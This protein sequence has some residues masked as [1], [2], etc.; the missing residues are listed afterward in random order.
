MSISSCETRR[1]KCACSRKADDRGSRHLVLLVRL[2][3][4]LLIVSGC[5]QLYSINSRATI[6]D[7]KACDSITLRFVHEMESATYSSG[8]TGMRRVLLCIDAPKSLGRLTG[9]T[10]EECEIYRDSRSDD[11]LL[12]KEFLA[13]EVRANDDCSRIWVVLLPDRRVVATLDRSLSKL[14]GYGEKPPEWAA[15]DGGHVVAPPPGHRVDVN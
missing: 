7:W 9:E 15:L 2:S 12:I 11:G 8:S 1:F 6:G 4:I 14:T 13:C 5:A 10:T 3:P